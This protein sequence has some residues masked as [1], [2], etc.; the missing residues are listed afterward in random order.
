VVRADE[1]AASPTA[2]LAKEQRATDDRI[3]PFIENRI[4]ALCA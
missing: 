2:A 1:M 4:T 3:T